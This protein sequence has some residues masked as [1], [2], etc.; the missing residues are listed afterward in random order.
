MNTPIKWGILGPG[1]IAHKFAQGLKTLPQARIQA[2]ASRDLEKSQAFAGTYAIPSAYDSYEALAADP[3]VDIVYVATPHAFHHEHT[4]LCL[5]NGKHVLCEKPMALNAAQV[6]EM[7]TTARQHGR[8]LMEAMW[9]YF[10]P[11]WKQVGEWIASGAIGE[12]RQFHADFSFQGEYNP[13]NRLYNPA[14]AGGALLDVGIYPISMAFWVFK[15]NPDAVASLASLSETGVD[16]QSAYLFRYNRGE[17]AILN[18]SFEV[19]GT[20]EA[21]IEGTLGKIRVPLFWR[22]QEAFLELQDG[23]TSSVNIPH[24]ATGLEYEAAAVMDDLIANR[25]ESA[26]F[27][28]ADSLR[29]ATMFDRLRK[30][31]GMRYP[32]EQD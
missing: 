27:P 29:I 1:K 19:H 25:L 7:I 20:K 23:T 30:D 31:W 17:M 14:L 6:Q 10:L 32:G 28:Q 24:E 4:L 22:A 18:S 13:A 2:V 11:V 12:I 9:T 15:R 21:V 26:I 8:Y 3:E 5:R 16:A